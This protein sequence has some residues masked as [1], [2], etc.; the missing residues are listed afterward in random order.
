MTQA[1]QPRRLIK[2]PARTGCVQRVTVLQN[3]GQ[4]I[5]RENGHQT[6]SI[7]VVGDT[8]TVIAL[9]SAVVQCFVPTKQYEKQDGKQKTKTQYLIGDFWKAKTSNKHQTYKHY[10]GGF[11]DDDSSKHVGR[12]SDAVV[13][14]SST[15]YKART[16]RRR[17]R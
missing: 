6:T 3:F 12:G 11:N 8:A 10:N 15:R 4:K 5:F 2:N 17:D 7:F 14:C 9:A 16:G 13:H 1:I